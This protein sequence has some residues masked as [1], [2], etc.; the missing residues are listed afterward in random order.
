MDLWSLL[1]KGRAQR[2]PGTHQ[3]ASPGESVSSEFND[4]PVSKQKFFSGKGNRGR[5]QTQGMQTRDC[6][7]QG[8]RQPGPEGHTSPLRSVTSLSLLYY[9]FHWSWML[10]AVLSTAVFFKQK[11][12]LL[13]FCKLISVAIA[14][15]SHKPGGLPRCFGPSQTFSTVHPRAVSLKMPSDFKSR[16]DKREKIKQE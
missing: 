9:A 13:I 1:W 7:P 12:V 6:L 14:V 11:S 5:T 10:A 4:T 2:T 3:P 8:Q 16:E 15:Y